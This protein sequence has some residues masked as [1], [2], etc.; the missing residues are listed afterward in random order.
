MAEAQFDLN[1]ITI[2]SR[3]LTPQ[4]KLAEIQFGGIPT[5]FE[6]IPDDLV[7]LDEQI[8]QHVPEPKGQTVV[9]FLTNQG[10]ETWGY[11]RTKNVLLDSSKPL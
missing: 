4:Y 5:E 10:Q 7:W 1:S 11:S 3:Q 8:A 9:A 2:F 6:S